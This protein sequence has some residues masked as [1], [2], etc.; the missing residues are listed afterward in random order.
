MPTTVEDKELRSSP[1]PRQARR[2]TLTAAPTDTNVMDDTAGMS[3]PETTQSSWRTPRQQTPK[4]STTSPYPS[5][6]QQQ[7]QQ[8]SQDSSDYFLGSS[9]SDPNS[10]SYNGDNDAPPS[11]TPATNRGSVWSRIR[12]QQPQAQSQSSQR[13]SSP[14]YSRKQA[15]SMQ[16]EFEDGSA[17]YSDTY[18]SSPSAPAPPSS[19]FSR[20]PNPNQNQNQDKSAAQREFDEMLERERRGVG[21]SDISQTSRQQGQ[22]FASGYDDGGST[23]AGGENAWENRRR[24]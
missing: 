24:R 23:T 14:T 13:G 1:L 10:P 19:R 3:Q 17:A 16:Y 4:P 9:S 18:S 22:Q 5:Q 20:N 11:S 7:Q 21:G 6:Q 12:Q 2:P 15:G 8:N